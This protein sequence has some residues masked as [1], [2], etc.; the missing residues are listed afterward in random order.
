MT[1]SHHV[2]FRRFGSHP[3]PETW[4]GLFSIHFIS[5]NLASLPSS[6][7]YGGYR[8]YHR[9]HPPA[10]SRGSTRIPTRTL[11]NFCTATYDECC[12][13]RIRSKKTVTSNDLRRVDITV[14]FDKVNHN[15]LVSKVARSTFPEATCRWLS[16]N[17][18][19]QQTVRSCRGVKFSTWIVHTGVPFRKA[20]CCPHGYP[21]ST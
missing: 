12:R 1:P 17:I 9:Q 6:K 18:T 11:N 2:E 20:R 4:Q 7:S 19:G 16:N 10:P 13:N 5:A 21:F 8:D 14:G 15:V 3:H